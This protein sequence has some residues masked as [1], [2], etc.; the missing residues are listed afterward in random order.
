M[1]R[2]IKYAKPFGSEADAKIIKSILNVDTDIPPKLWNEIN[3]VYQQNRRANWI[4]RNLI[5]IG[6]IGLWYLAINTVLLVIF[7][8][9]LISGVDVIGW[10]T[11]LLGVN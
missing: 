7:G 9:L 6:K 10:Y 2:D 4:S 11:E 8:S 3:K 5:R 1:N